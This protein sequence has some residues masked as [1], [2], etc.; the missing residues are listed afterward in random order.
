MYM[1]KYILN[2]LYY[3]IINSYRDDTNNNYN[4][5]PNILIIDK[6][7][8]IT[9]AD[10]IQI[11]NIKTSDY[12]EKYLI[13]KC[14]DKKIKQDK[15]KS[16][17]EQNKIKYEYIT[18]S[19]NKPKNYSIYDQMKNYK[20]VGIIDLIL[21]IY[22]DKMYRKYNLEP[23]SY[24]GAAC[25]SN[26]IRFVSQYVMKIN[27]NIIINDIVGGN[28]LETI[29]E[30]RRL[31][32]LSYHANWFLIIYTLIKYNIYGGKK[33]DTLDDIS[34]LNVIILYSNKK[35]DSHMISLINDKDNILLYDSNFGI[36][37]LDSIKD[38]E[39][40]INILLPIYNC[41]KYLIKEFDKVGKIF[42][43]IKSLNKN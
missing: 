4:Y 38:V 29:I 11:C 20:Y 41:D 23:V 10:Y 1:G 36:F 42:S 19:S 17:L 22:Y 21:Y 9:F 5:N 31:N 14:V 33:S 43:K 3:L 16:I 35:S 40:I 39:K 2:Q 24:L 15:I 7:K 25:F 13:D 6:K 30:N 32:Y 18:T 26:S 37:K 8:S 28:D 27:E 12:S 34:K